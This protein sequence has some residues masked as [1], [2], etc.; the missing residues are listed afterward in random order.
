[1][2]LGVLGAFVANLI[3]K[4]QHTNGGIEIRLYIAEVLVLQASNR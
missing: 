2:Q 3:R 1:V 4:P